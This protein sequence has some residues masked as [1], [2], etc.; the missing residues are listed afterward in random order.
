MNQ[1][2][3]IQQIKEAF[4]EVPKP[5]NHFGIYTARAHDEY[6]E[7]TEEEQAQDR[8][9]DRYDL[10]PLQMHECYTALSFLE[11]AGFHYYLPAFMI[12]ALQQNE[13]KEKALKDSIVFESTDFALNPTQN[14]DLKDYQEKR[15]RRLTQSQI[16]AILAYLQQRQQMHSW[17]HKFYE[18]VIHYWANRRGADLLT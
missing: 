18:K 8:M 14:L 6:E 9:L 4:A 5:Y 7:P 17:N 2:D 12:L 11:P 3:L 16:D 10:T 15:F 13:I 1:S